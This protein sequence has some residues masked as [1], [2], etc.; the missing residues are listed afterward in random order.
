MRAKRPSHV[1][2]VDLRLNM[3]FFLLSVRAVSSLVACS[4]AAPAPNPVIEERQLLGSVLSGVATLVPSVVSGVAADATD[5]AGI[6]SALLVA[7]EDTKPTKTPTSIPR[8]LDVACDNFRADLKQRQLLFFPAFS[9]QRRPIYT[10]T[11]LS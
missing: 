5:A 9:A 11:A 8:K 1:N 2:P 6:Y 4:I 10:K 3:R 7:V